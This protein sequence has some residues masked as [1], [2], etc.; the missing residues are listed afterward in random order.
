[1]VPAAYVLPN[2]SEHTVE[3]HSSPGPPDCQPPPARHW[4]RF[5]RGQFAQLFSLAWSSQ[6]ELPSMCAWPL[7]GGRG[8]RGDGVREKKAPRE[9]FYIKNSLFSYRDWT[10]SQILITIF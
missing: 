5:H 3:Y 9:Y 2:S 10:E 6:Q 4:P 8:R 1:M 7:C